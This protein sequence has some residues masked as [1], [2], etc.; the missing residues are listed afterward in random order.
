MGRKTFESIGSKALPDR[1][2][3]VLSGKPVEGAS[4]AQSLNEAVAQATHEIYIIGGGQIY[5]Q[6]LELANMVYATEVQH[7]FSDVDTFFPELGGSWQEIARVQH[8]AD[9]KNKY[10]F[11]FVEYQRN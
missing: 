10:S 3:I 11:D 9:A 5:K 4:W 8:L 1:E 6:A 2:N 7:S